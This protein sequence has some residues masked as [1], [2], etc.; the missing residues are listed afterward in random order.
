MNVT[1]VALLQKLLIPR[2]QGTPQLI[3]VP[4][5]VVVDRRCKVV[6]RRCKVVDRQ[7]K[8][9]DR[10]LP[11]LVHHQVSPHRTTEGQP[12]KARTSLHL[13]VGGIYS[14]RKRK[15]PV[16]ILRHH[17]N[18]SPNMPSLKLVI[19]TRNH[20]V[21]HC[22]ISMENCLVTYSLPRVKGLPSSLVRQRRMTGGRAP[23]MERQEF[24]QQIMSH[25]NVTTIII[26]TYC[27]YCISIYELLSIAKLPFV[28][29]FAKGVV[30]TH[31]IF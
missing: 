11:A 22:I 31:L 8:A 14:R 30:S 2:H 25:C 16:T 6:D 18:R 15:K 12:I 27:L 7:Y 1:W 3:L 5:V 9:V 17:V 13:K 24:S 28:T 4:A 19:G 20:T 21:G 29:E 23:L 26:N 10:I